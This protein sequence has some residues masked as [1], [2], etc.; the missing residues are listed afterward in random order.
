VVVGWLIE[1]VLMDTSQA[2]RCVMLTTV[3]DCSTILQYQ[4][5]LILVS[6]G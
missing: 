3:E 2:G 6:G 5:W 4:H 1:V